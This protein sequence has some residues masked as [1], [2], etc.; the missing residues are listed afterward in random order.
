MRR[1]SHVELDAPRA[2]SWSPATLDSRLS[3]DSSNS[4]SRRACTLGAAPV[5]V[6]LCSRGRGL[7]PSVGHP[8]DIRAPLTPQRRPRLLCPCPS[9]PFSFSPLAPSCLAFARLRVLTFVHPVTPPSFLSHRCAR[10]RRRVPTSS[11]HRPHPPSRRASSQSK[12][13]RASR[14]RPAGRPPCTRS[15]AAPGA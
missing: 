14:C 15:C 10:R 4:V 7:P 8:E 9:P 1:F 13:R 6:R 11:P 12:G 5:P 2:L 3:D